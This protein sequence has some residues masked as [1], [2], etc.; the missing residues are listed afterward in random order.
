MRKMK[1][2]TCLTPVDDDFVQITELDD[3]N[4]Y[5]PEGST[6]TAKNRF[7]FEDTASIDIFR[8]NSTEG[9]K[10]TP[11][12]TILRDNLRTSQ[13]KLNSD[14]WFTAIHIVIP[15]KDWVYRELSKK[16]SIIH[17]YDRVYFTDGNEIYT[18]IK[19]ELNRTTL[20]T[21]LD[22]ISDNTTISRTDTDYVSIS[23]LLK[24]LTEAYKTL[25]QNRMY[26]GGCKTN[27]CEANRLQAAVNL[28]RHYVRMGQLAEAERIIEKV[29]YFNSPIPNK[30]SRKDTKTYNDCGCS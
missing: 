26:N 28:I 23:R 5:L 10:D 15:T 4:Q 21:L 30:H 24:Q 27:A 13:I 1:F 20:Q 19:G 16:N 12:V 14:G 29:N 9:Q 22:E 17:T 7:R 18:C 3:G 2:K 6:L 8:L 11:A 25:F